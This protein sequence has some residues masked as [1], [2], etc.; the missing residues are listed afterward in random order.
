MHMKY[1]QKMTICLCDII[2]YDILYLENYLYSL[3]ITKNPI[4]GFPVG[5]NGPRPMPWPGVRLSYQIRVVDE[6]M[7]DEATRGPNEDFGRIWLPCRLGSP[8]WQLST[9]SDSHGLIGA[10]F[11]MI[12]ASLWGACLR[13]GA[14]DSQ[15]PDQGPSSLPDGLRPRPPSWPLGDSEIGWRLWRMPAPSLAWTLGPK[16]LQS[17]HPGARG[18]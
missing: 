18:P 4:P 5:H 13:P 7:A 9:G 11:A 1:L 10:G 3:V 17:S 6:R 8:D 15:M 12:G 14:W 16:G 2:F